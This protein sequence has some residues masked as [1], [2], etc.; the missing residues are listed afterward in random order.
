MLPLIRAGLLGL[1]LALTGWPETARAVS[2]ELNAVASFFI[3]GLGQ[4]ANG[5]YD[6]GAIQFGAALV[7]ARQSVI[8]GEKDDYIPPEDRLDEDNNEIRLN[9]TSF[10]AD[11][12][13]IA[14]LD[15]QFYSSFS[16]YRDAR[17]ALDNAG[18]ATRAPR[19]T[20]TDLMV[21]PF[22]W[23]FL[24][25]PTTFVPLLIPLYLVLTPA[26]EERLIFAP[27]RSI[28]REEMAA[29]FF[30]QQGG[31][32]IGEE[33]FFRGVLN[34]GLSSRFGDTVGLL[35]SSAAFGLAHIGLPG[36]ANA[37]TAGLFGLY[38]GWLH[39]R[40][41]YEIGEGVAIHFWWNFLLSLAMLAEREEARQIVLY[42]YYARF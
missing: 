9:R 32:A 34:N 22:R 20:I 7:L 17:L 15:L 1:A 31:V 38:L 13:S 14:S 24:S 8:L 4:A 5:D 41:G 37:L 28:S 33:A 18:Y 30:V 19:E 40:N 42:T 27:D 16:A 11:L 26:D 21:A 36:Q 3:P 25:R 39:Q 23:E 10:F 29:W 6:A 2:P 35:G 12:Y